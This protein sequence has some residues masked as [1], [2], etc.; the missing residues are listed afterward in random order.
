MGGK[1]FVL[2]MTADQDFEALKK[3]DIVGKC[4]ESIESLTDDLIKVTINLDVENEIGF[5]VVDWCFRRNDIINM[6]EKVGFS[7]IKIEKSLPLDPRRWGYQSDMAQWCDDSVYTIFTAEKLP[8]KKV[9]HA[10][11]ASDPR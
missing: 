9:H 5:T 1:T 10:T 8:I 11:P 7:N 3:N 2:C 6:M 4:V